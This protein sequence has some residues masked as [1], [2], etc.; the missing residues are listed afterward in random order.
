MRSTKT[1]LNNEE[2]IIFSFFIGILCLSSMF[3]FIPFF[4]L[5]TY[6]DFFLLI[7][8]IFYCY[9]YILNHH[10][11]SQFNASWIIH[12]FILWNIVTIIRGYFL[13]ETYWDYKTTTQNALY[14]L[15]FI[16]IFI[17]S[18][19]NLIQSFYRFIIKYYFFIAIAV[20]Y[21]SENWFF[22][23]LMF[24]PLFYLI[25]FS[26]ELKGKYVWFVLLL[27]ILPLPFNLSNRGYVLRIGVSLLFFGYLR[28]G[29][30]LSFKTRTSMIKFLY[31]FI[32]ITPIIL[33][34]L[35][36]TSIFNIFEIGEDKEIIYTQG[37]YE[38]N[39]LNDTRTFLYKDI[40]QVVKDKGNVLIGNGA[41]G[42]SNSDLWMETDLSDF[43]GRYGSESGLLN[44]FL[45]S[46]LI[47]SILFY[48]IHIIS[49]YFAIYKSKSFLV[50]M[51]GLY[52]A[53]RL[54]C[55]FFDEPASWKASNA[56]HF[57]SIG[58]CLSK[59]FRALYDSEIKEWVKG[60]IK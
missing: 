11:A 29:K 7:G 58:L 45:N 39:L 47:G 9:K 25:L 27:A 15:L 6:L 8:Y 54:G 2:K 1:I 4:L 59:P 26:A 19:L 23:Q 37:D 46:G 28:F 55:A 40:Y 32:I 53:F 50:K 5:S 57:L 49:S 13:A 20:L 14:F 43:G 34:I 41:C 3:Y 51:I 52:V 35:A 36:T 12:L 30:L 22:L 44:M 38:G 17:S 56:L 31:P 60:M 18:N 21:F 33:T 16:T 24:M 48:L 42:K 10:V